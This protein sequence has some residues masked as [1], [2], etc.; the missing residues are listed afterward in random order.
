MKQTTEIKKGYDSQAAVYDI[1]DVPYLV[2]CFYQD[3]V[4]VIL[5]QASKFY[6]KKIVRIGLVTII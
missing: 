6:G 5:D 2:D 4:C 3:D 1:D